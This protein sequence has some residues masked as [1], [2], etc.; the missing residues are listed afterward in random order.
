MS[1]N[2]LDK[3]YT[4]IQDI[5]PVPNFIKIRRFENIFST[6]GWLKRLVNYDRLVVLIEIFSM[7]GNKI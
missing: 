4:I 1:E 5:R 6:I 3:K 2:L 7:C